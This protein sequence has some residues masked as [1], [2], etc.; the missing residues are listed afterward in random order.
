MELSKSDTTGIKGIAILFMLWH[1]LFLKTTEYGAFTQSLAVAFKVCVALFLFVSGYGLAKQYGGLDCRSVNNTIRFLLR[2]FI[3]FFLP[4]WFCFV[5]V[6]LIGNLC[7]YTFQDVYPSTRNTFKCILLDFF[8]QMGYNS[9]LNPWWFNKM[10]IQLYLVFP[11]LYLITVNKYSASVGLVT[12]ILVQLFAKSIPGDAFF[13]VEGGLPAFYLGIVSARYRIIPSTQRREWKVVWASVSFVL[14]IG[15]A[16]FHQT[17]MTKDAYQAILIRA[18][19]AFCIV[20]AYKC[21]DGHHTPIWAFIGKYATVMYLTHVLLII[22]I[23]NIV[24]FPRY[25]VLVFFSFSVACLIVAMV[26]SW[27]ENILLYDKL[28]LALV[29]LVNKI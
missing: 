24:F 18:F 1:H 12:I 21:F 23:P 4:Y 22:L 19:L 13:M 8:G 2:R 25:S 7:G 11:F 28:R 3:N 15:L 9:Y 5:L 17:V 10:I 6:A 16:I 27:L 26:I 20:F 14:V 29:N